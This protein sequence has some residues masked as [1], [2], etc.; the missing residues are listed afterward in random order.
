L[1]HFQNQDFSQ[2]AYTHFAMPGT[3]N[4][5]FFNALQ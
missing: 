2:L 1:T 4:R 3:K 5:I